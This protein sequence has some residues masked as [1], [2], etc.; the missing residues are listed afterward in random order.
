[1][2]ISLTVVSDLKYYKKVVP[3]VLVVFVVTFAVI[4]THGY[5]PIALSRL[6]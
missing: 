4:L 3:V 1:M 2:S 6:S 5:A